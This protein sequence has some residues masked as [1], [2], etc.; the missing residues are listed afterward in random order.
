MNWSFGII[1]TEVGM[2]SWGVI[3]Y[4]PTFSCKLYAS[5]TYIQ[6]GKIIIKIMIYES[7]DYI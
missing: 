6:M 4:W 7:F 2:L 1:R 5:V 3:N